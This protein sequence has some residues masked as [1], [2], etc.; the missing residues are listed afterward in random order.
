MSLSPYEY[1]SIVETAPNLI[2]RSGLDAKCY[3]FNKTWLDF[4]GR[5]FEQ[6]FGDGW[7]EGVHPDDLD[8][9]IS[10]YLES[11]NKRIRFEMEYRLRRHDGEWRWINDIGVPAID[12]NG[13]FSGFIGSCLDVTERVVGFLLKEM[14][15]KDGLTETLSRQYLINLFEHEFESAKRTGSKLSVAMIDIDKFKSINDLYGHLGGDCALRMF[16]SV[17]KD[18]IRQN[19]L[20]GRYGGDEFLVIFPNNSIDEASKII[21]RIKSEL[22]KS[23]LKLEDDEITLSISVGLCELNDEDSPEELIKK[24]DKKMYDVKKE[25]KTLRGV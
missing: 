6:E 25:S 23:T 21:D 9:C 17:V 14:A 12:E 15:Q 19:D 2:W 22:T 7:A 10:I 16:S 5:S 3:Y 8:R 11:F 18:T 20:F 4:T 24:A 13:D 1:K